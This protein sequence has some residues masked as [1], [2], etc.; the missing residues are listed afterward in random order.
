MKRLFCYVSVLTAGVWAVSHRNTSNETFPSD[1]LIGAA[2]SAF[3]IEG[4]WNE[5]GM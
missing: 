5:S 1:F 4:A 3:Q 2:T